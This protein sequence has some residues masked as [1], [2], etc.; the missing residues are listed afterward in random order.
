MEDSEMTEEADETSTPL[1][2]HKNHQ[3]QFQLA[4]SSIFQNSI[5]DFYE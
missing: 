4:R 1:Q 3:E 5:T 2:R